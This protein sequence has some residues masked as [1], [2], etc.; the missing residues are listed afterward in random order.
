LLTLTI[1]VGKNIKQ[2]EIIISAAIL[3][4]GPVAFDPYQP[5]Y[6]QFVLDENYDLIKQEGWIETDGGFL[7]V[8]GMNESNNLINRI[9]SD[10]LKTLGDHVIKY[11]RGNG[12]QPTKDGGLEWPFSA[13]QIFI[14]QKLLPENFDNK[15]LQNANFKEVQKG[16]VRD[17]LPGET[18]Y[19]PI[20]PLELAEEIVKCGQAGAAVVHTHTRNLTVIGNYEIPKAGFGII[21]YAQSN[22]IM[23]DGF[24]Q[25]AIQARKIAT[26]TGVKVPVL[27]FSTSTDAKPRDFQDKKVDGQDD[28]DP[29]LRTSHLQKYEFEKQEYKPEIASFSADTVWRNNRGYENSNDLCR[30]ML[31]DLASKGIRPEIEIFYDKMLDNVIEMKN[32]IN[33]CGSP[34][35][36]MLVGIGGDMGL[37]DKESGENC[38]L[39]DLDKIKNSQNRV[40]EISNQLTP[41]IGKIK[42]HFP[43]AKIG[44]LLGGWLQEH[45]EDV[46]HKVDADVI[47]VGLED[48]IT[49]RD[50]DGKTRLLTSSAERV[51][52]A[53]AKLEEMGYNVLNAEQARKN[54]ALSSQHEVTS[55]GRGNK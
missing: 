23:P 35:L 47:R 15:V 31:I 50:K 25:M 19:L 16:F 40:D 9:E 37:V 21:K 44:V 33:A 36:F 53:K 1:M 28:S 6:A 39:L 48:S 5:R 55:S 34:P 27:N 38:S 12:L 49:V 41:Y 14:P 18:P 8:V 43:G 45:I 51:A 4:A 29:A 22:H 24:E 7:L 17:L 46:V 52:M 54:L 26:E 42:E 10:V 20:T 32:L 11:L 2:K 13:G 30:A 3:G